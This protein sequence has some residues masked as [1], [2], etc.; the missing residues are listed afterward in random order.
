MVLV[1]QSRPAWNFYSHNPARLLT[2]S[3]T[4]SYLSSPRTPSS[5]PE[6]RKAIPSPKA[7]HDCW[8][9]GT[10][11]LELA[12]SCKELI[13]P[14][15]WFYLKCNIWLEQVVT[16]LFIY[17]FQQGSYFILWVKYACVNALVGILK[18]TFFRRI[19]WDKMKGM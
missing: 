9:T 14:R 7:K 11:K 1:L 13:F 6:H 19:T 10:Q 5:S 12:V 2:P 15:S 17:L 3:G 4:T 16:Y 8:S 18:N